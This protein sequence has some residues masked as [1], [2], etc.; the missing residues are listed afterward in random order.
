MP[1][2]TDVWMPTNAILEYAYSIICMSRGGKTSEY[3][4]IWGMNKSGNDR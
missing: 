1:V 2:S 3:Q 4:N